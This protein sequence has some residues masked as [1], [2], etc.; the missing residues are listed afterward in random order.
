M[1]AYA[2]WMPVN[3]ADESAEAELDWSG[4]QSLLLDEDT[5]F[6]ME[7]LQATFQ[8]LEAELRQQDV[9]EDSSTEYC[10]NFCQALMHYAGSRNSVEH[11]LPLLEVYCLSINCFAAARPHLTG[12]SPNV[13]LVL[14]RLALSCL[15]L[16]LSV[17]QNEIPLEAWLQF[18]GSVQAAHEAMLQYGSTD[19]HA[20]L[21][22]TGEG[23]AWNNP[24]LV[25][26]LTGQST[27]QEEVNAY[28]A[29]EGEGFMEMR[30]KHLEKVGEVEK[31]LILNKACA[32]CSLLPNQATFRQTFVTQ[33]CQ[34]L[35]SEEAILEISRIDA[36]DV[37]D[38]ICNMDAEGEESTAFIL[39]TTYFTQQLQQDNLDCSWELTLLWSK[40]QR[41]IDVSIESF[42]E[43]CLQFGAIARTIYHLLF[44]IR[45]I[46]TEA[47]QL[48][49]AVSV[50]LCV[51]AL[52]LPNQDVDS[53]T[54]VC[55][56]VACLLPED[57]EVIRACQ[58]TQ[59]L[60]CPAQE[61][62]D[63][64]EELYTRPDQKYDEENAII[65]NS[66]RCELL[67]SLKAHWPFDPE[68]WDWKTLKRYCSQLLGLE[69]EEE[70]E[71]EAVSEELC[72]VGAV[73]NEEAWKEEEGESEINVFSSTAQEQTVEKT[74]TEMG[75]KVL[76]K[77]DSVDVS[78]RFD[79]QEK[80]K[81]FCQICH[82]EVVETRI[83]H[84]AR[85]HME[86]DVWTCPVCLQRFKSKKEF[87]THTKTHIQIPAE[88]HWKKK[89]VKEKVDP[90]QYFKEDSIDE[91]EPGQIPLDPSLAMYYQSTH[92]PVV[93]EHILEKAASVPDKQVENDYITFDYIK[94]HYKLQNRDVYQCPASNC[95]KNFK[96]FKYLG[97]HI[98]NEHDSEDPNMKHY[99][100]MKDRREKC[101]FCRKTFMTAF[102]HRQHRWV[103]YGDNPFMCL[104]TGC[105]ARF[106]TTNGLIA[107]KHSHGFRLSYGCELKGC[108]FSYCDLGQLYH[109][110]AQHFRD[111]A[112]TCTSPGCKNFFYS[113]KEFLQHMATHDITF[114]EKDFE[115]QRKMKRKLLLPVVES[116]ESKAEVE[117]G[118]QKGSG[119]SQLLANRESKV[120]LTCVAVCFDGRK[121]TCGLKRCGRTFTT[122][123]EL[124]KHLRIAHPDKFNEEQ[125]CKKK[126]QA[127]HSKTQAN[128]LSKSGQDNTVRRSST[129]ELN[130]EKAPSPAPESKDCD[131]TLSSV[132]IGAALSE[133]MLGLSQLS[134]NSPSTRYATRNSQSTCMPTLKARSPAK[135]SNNK[136]EMRSRVSSSDSKKLPD[137]PE[138]PQKR[139]NSK[140]PEKKQLQSKLSTKPYTCEA[141]SCRYQSVTTCALMQHYINIHGYSEE[142]VKQMEVFQSQTFK[143]SKMLDSTGNSV[144]EDDQPH[145]EFLVQATT[146]PYTCE[147]KSCHYQ[148]VTSY[149]LM[150][151]YIKIHAYSEEE[152][153]EMEVFQSQKFK[154]FK[155]HLCSKSYKNKKA[156]RVHYIRMHHINKAV[157]EQMSCSFKRKLAEKAPVVSS[158]KVRTRKKSQSL[159]RDDVKTQRREKH[160][161]QQKCQKQDYRLWKR[162]LHRK[163]GQAE[164]KSQVPSKT[165]AHVN[166]SNVDVRGS[167]RLVAKGNLSYILSKYNKPFH[168]VHKN[169]SA[170]FNTQ[171]ALV[172]HLQLVHHYNRSQLCFPCEHKGC[173]KQFNNLSS[174][175]KH[176]HRE[177]NKKITSKMPCKSKNIAKR[178]MT[179]SEEPIPRFKCTYANC[180]ESY[181][182][183]SSLLRHTSQFHQNQTPLNPVATSVN[184]EFK[185]SYKKHVFYRHC[186][187]S[188]SLVVRLQSTPKKDESN[189]GCQTKL[190]ISPSSQLSKDSQKLPLR[191]CLKDQEIS[192]SDKN[193]ESMEETAE[194]ELEEVPKKPK[195]KLKRGFD[196]IV[197]RTHEE[198]LQMCQDRCFPVAFPCMV[199]NCDSVV[200]S[201]RSLNRHYISVHKVRRKQLTE[202]E[203]KLCYTAEKL[204]EIIQKKSAV[205]AI[206]DLT[207]I[208]NGVL[209]MEYQSEPATPGGPSLP[210]SLHSIKTESK[211]QEVIEFS[212]EPLPDRSLLIAAEDLLYG[213]PKSSGHPEESV[214]EESQRHK[215]SSEL[216]STAPPLIRPPPLDLSPPSTLRIAVDESSF[217]PSGKDSK[218]I[219]IPSTISISAPTPTRQ[220]L[221]RK[222]ELSEPPPPVPLLPISKDPVTHS[223]AP[224]AFDFATYKPMGFES[225][226]LKFIKEKDEIQIEKPWTAV[227]NKPDP[228]R[229]RD[230]F[231]RNCSVKEN[232]QRGAPISRSRKFHSS[233]LR[234]LISKGEC[235]S[236]QNLRLILERAL[237]GCGDQAI[238]QLQFLKP[239][240]VLERPKSFASILDLLPSETKA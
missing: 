54:M 96:L 95:S 186:D 20:L 170:A 166:H 89:K 75:Q 58:L 149:A 189:S 219:N 59:F 191:C 99:L 40:L 61:A 79:K 111:A 62:F 155:C 83:C 84:H 70:V 198:A 22:I 214:T 204:E 222:N 119:S 215:D 237:G 121:F 37:L 162:K 207:R 29:L 27:D 10:N 100:E 19:L 34:L 1:C 205:S 90:K 163:N 178:Q 120:S 123:R 173:D 150:K 175:T 109:H 125:L 108:S 140:D 131:T 157:V 25:S 197:F 52:R 223:L 15:E 45:V 32:N 110:E 118:V 195:I 193:F 211:G 17:P 230:C 13:A 133:I 183:N 107:H 35:P 5:F 9:S 128:E 97:V 145:S 67:L 26:L 239:V 139:D 187:P 172:G 224:R 60:L 16:L 182:L 113:R 76:K 85:K 238:K 74:E 93:L 194:E 164:E 6:A 169:C 104:V 73:V 126:V 209:K 92:D 147:A 33:L 43:R 91:L 227:V 49:L 24:V 124:Q 202:H 122:V 117:N 66:L 72:N 50:E 220:P 181:H 105:G 134:L 2:P 98:K 63:V 201:M 87:E 12:D 196:R 165:D 151:H 23:G 138:S 192:R 231:R 88:G 130:D 229:R 200:M 212:G 101:T 65:P 141:K 78:R 94:T 152:V 136:N 48:G 46:Q 159:K 142:K 129:E 8:Q 228:P 206:P 225:S 38:I 188:D 115:T 80:N 137:K 161:W 77:K 71:D 135:A 144:L 30:I 143:P 86:D 226:F 53:K 146:K 68:F 55:K 199:Q 51:K 39:C 57:L 190:I 42:I 203:E 217:E 154:P 41:R 102:H 36:K 208:P 216:E 179:S 156:L 21:N 7:A 176:Y 240:V 174:L 103:H 69:P 235:T 177:H 116:S 4:R 82:K 185:S 167:R 11:G 184:R 236:I 210:M 127:K 106:E 158:S 160:P 153:K 132:E 112:Y 232:T 180:N 3:M 171:N 44:L 233:P 234:H 168:C 218:S 47:V 114:T 81:F 221:R 148:S 14:K 56:A 18:H 213:S 31:A 64:L 28:L